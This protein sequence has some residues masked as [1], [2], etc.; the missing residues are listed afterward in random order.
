M[1]GDRKLGRHPHPGYAGA[2]MRLTVLP[3]LV[4][5]ASLSACGP[6]L[7]GPS[8]QVASQAQLAPPIT[9]GA[10][11]SLDGHPTCAMLQAWLAAVDGD[12]G[13]K[14]LYA[15]YY[16][17]RADVPPAVDVLADFSLLRYQ[18]GGF[19]PRRIIDEA[20]CAVMAQRRVDG[21]W[22]NVRVGPVL[23]SPLNAASPAVPEAE[24]A[25]VPRNDAERVAKIAALADWLMAR[26]RFSGS[27]VVVHRGATILARSWGLAS[28]AYGV[29]NRVDTKFNLGSMNKMFTAVSILQLVE[30][31]KVSLDDKAGKWL[32]DWPNAD[33]R[34]K[35]TVRMLLTHSSGLGSYWN[36]EF[37]RRKVHIRA[38]ADYFPTFAS[39]PLQFPPGARFSY[40]NA[41]F[42]VLGAIVEKVSGEDYFNYVRRHVYAPAG[43]TDS[44]CYDP[45]EDVPNL[46]VGYTRADPDGKLDFSRWHNNLF[47]ITKGGP[48]G[49]GYSTSPDLVRFAAALLG[50]KLLRP[51][52]FATMS[53]KQ[54]D[55]PIGPMAVRSLRNAGY[56]FGMGRSKVRGTLFIGHSGGAPGINSMLNMSEDG[57]WIL[58]VMTNGEE[59][60]NDLG[61]YIRDLITRT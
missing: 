41:G 28:R 7:C 9:I 37:E 26:D 3:L 35:V 58:A 48:A 23:D 56:G 45:W 25:P 4:L 59:G 49:G 8:S 18:S 19:V 60:A 17:G 22:T 12:A 57:Q 36:E 39:Q 11:V 31:H 20:T 30:Q 14:A 55:V 29:P 40:S 15:Q 54:I 53:G 1:P 61:Q 13:A 2:W 43:M 42:I 24:D 46:A 51:A 50:G 34:D 44:D 27:I 21:L 32:P 10:P 33:V 52:T 47:F 16:A 6:K 5:L 38:V